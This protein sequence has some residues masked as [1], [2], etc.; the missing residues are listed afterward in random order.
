[1]L[2]AAP[3]AGPT[4]PQPAQV[5]KSSKYQSGGEVSLDKLL[6]EKEQPIQLTIPLAFPPSGSLPSA[7][8]SLAS[9]T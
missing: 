8:G 5:K 9:S 7:D 3:A 1:M 2:R 4:P 6:S